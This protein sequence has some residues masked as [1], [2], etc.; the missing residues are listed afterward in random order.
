[1]KRGYHRNKCLRRSDN[2]NPS[3]LKAPPFPRPPKQK[4][5]KT[6]FSP[7][8]LENLGVEFFWKKKNS[9]PRFPLVQKNSQNLTPPPQFFAPFKIFFPFFVFYRGGG[10]G[11]KI[12]YYPTHSSSVFTE[13]LFNVRPRNVEASS[14]G[15]TSATSLKKKKLHTPAK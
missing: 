1:V 8:F 6:N 10:E 14:L 11:G 7:N 3:I 4:K 5:T 12:P 15:V 9:P 13:S 2:L